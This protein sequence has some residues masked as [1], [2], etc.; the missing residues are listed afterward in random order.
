MNHKKY[1]ILLA[2]FF[3]IFVISIIYVIPYSKEHTDMLTYKR[4]LTKKLILEY[5]MYPKRTINVMV[6]ENEILRKM[7]KDIDNSP[8]GLAIYGS[9]ISILLLFTISM[10][11][12]MEYSYYKSEQEQYDFDRRMKKFF[13]EKEM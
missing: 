11:Y 9:C 5:P 7:K 1:I 3:L 13:E 12:Y 2:L 8:F 6:E 10:F 4:E